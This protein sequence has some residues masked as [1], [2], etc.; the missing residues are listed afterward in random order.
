LDETRGEGLWE[1]YGETVRTLYAVSHCRV[2]E[3]PF[4]FTALRKL[5]DNSRVHEGY[6]YSYALVHEH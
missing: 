1:E 2:V 3:S 4:P 5:S 6:G